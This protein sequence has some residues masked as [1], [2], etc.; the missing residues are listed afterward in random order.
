MVRARKLW[1]V[2][3]AATLA[4]GSACGSDELNE[5]ERQIIGTVVTAGMG[6]EDDP[7]VRA[8]TARILEVLGDARFNPVV[9]GKID[10][11]KSMMVRVASLR[12]LLSSGD[13]DA[14]RLLLGLYNEANDSAKRAL[15][16]AAFEY[17]DQATQD[18]VV[19]RAVR[20]KDMTLKRR[21][22]ERG[23]LGKIDAALE[24]GDDELL[25]TEL[26]PMLSKYLEDRDTFLAARALRKFIELGEPE[27]ADPVKERFLSEKTPL[28]ERLRYARL[29][30]LAR[31]QKMKP[32]F[33][34]MAREKIDKARIEKLGLPA[35][36]MDPRLRRAAILGAVALG[37]EEFVKVA[38]GYTVK[39]TPEETIDVLEAYGSNPSKDA[40]ISLKI[41]MQD[42]RAP[43]RHRAIEIYG[44][45]EQ[46]EADAL[47]KALRQEDPQTKRMVAEVLVDRFPEDWAQNLR[48]QL[49]TEDRIDPTL[50]LLRDVIEGPEK[51]AVL[52]GLQEKLLALTQSEKPD[53]AAAAAYLLLLSAPNEESYH[54]IMRKTTNVQ[55]RYVYLEH[56]LRYRP[57]ASKDV[58]RSFLN[59][60]LFALRLV[61]AAGLWR[62]YEDPKLV[63]KEE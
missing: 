62:A 18:E 8:E 12:A 10:S 52:Q 54:E 59:A 23:P 30:R 31:V 55:S 21:A 2:V 46:A 24:A 16:D 61:S 58:F 42:A 33:V 6:V 32:L 41:A 34:E 38:Q 44:E 20:S 17:G 36:R 22:F 63:K 40:T 35:E 9:V 48:F 45:R 47:V 57:V 3:A 50:A 14:G 28:E 43:V 13:D 37:D 11:D 53:R 4:L 49:E 51:A 19:A 1:V 56:L 60:D 15:L 27:R 5:R 26:K 7:Y 25:K 29:L 39:A